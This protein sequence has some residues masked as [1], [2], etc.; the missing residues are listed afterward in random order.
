MTWSPVSWCSTH[1]SGVASVLTITNCSVIQLLT[2]PS[3]ITWLQ[4]WRQTMGHSHIIQYNNGDNIYKIPMAAFP[5]QFLQSMHWGGK[6]VYELKFQTLRP[7]AMDI[8]LTRNINITSWWVAPVVN[9][10]L[11]KLQ[12]RQLLLLQETVSR[13]SMIPVPQCLESRVH[14]NAVNTSCVTFLRLNSSTNSIEGTLENDAL[15]E[16]SLLKTHSRN[17][18]RY[19]GARVGNWRRP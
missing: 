18:P 10:A 3:I 17:I 19:S 7:L 13:V 15:K 1:S 2:L 6:G 9:P 11:T 4:T 16:L 5:A 12:A 14:M 8:F